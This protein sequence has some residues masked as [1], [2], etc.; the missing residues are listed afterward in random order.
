MTNEE[1][2]LHLTTKI[3]ALESAN[4]QLSADY[5]R[6][7]ADYT[8]L[9]ANYENIIADN[10]KLA[11]LIG[12]KDA[13]IANL[14][15]KIKDLEEKINQNP[16]NS[17]KPPSSEP[18]WKERKKK[19]PSGKKKG[20]QPGHEG[21]SR[22]LL[23]IEQVDERHSI[24]PETCN[25][26]GHS[27]R[28]NARKVGEPDIRQRIELPTKLYH[29]TQFE[30][31]TLECPCCGKATRAE[32]PSDEL[33]MMFGPRMSAFICM[34]T[35]WFRISRREAC[36]MLEEVF[37]IH[38][39]VGTI[40]KLEKRMAKATKEEYEAIRQAVLRE[41]V[42]GIDETGWSD[43]Q[44][45]WT[46]QSSMYSLFSI[47]PGR[48]TNDL[49]SIIG[50]YDGYVMSDRYG[51]YNAIELDK[52]QSCQAH[53]SR[54]YKAVKERGGEHEE[55]AD[56]LIALKDKVFF[57]W[58]RFKSGEISRE[59]L[60]MQ[61]KLPIEMFEALLE[62]GK[63]MNLPKTSG[64]CKNLLKLFPSLWRFIFVE[65]VDPT[66]NGSE[67]DIRKPVLW[68]KSSFGSRSE[69][70]ARYAEQLP[71]ICGTAKKQGLAKLFHIA[72][73]FAKFYNLPLLASNPAL[74]P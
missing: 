11:D 50:D 27:F 7:S 36:N 18:P 21:H 3:K 55:L 23:P 58:H 9:S 5:T 65:G 71:S 49:L 38:V 14:E 29:L 68:R 47:R 46:L 13:F 52:R 56:K 26:C 64:L 16:S 73:L 2:I 6:L 24:D 25:S 59:E 43:K 37:G 69:T 12:N 57:E 40:S 54:D 35:S 10:R 53:L 41:K 17:S 34:M 22:K 72:N 70:G 30:Y 1:I 8:R 42:V 28:G 39:S 62:R 48:S 19:K 63:K 67:R 32:I 15:Q 20:G 61:S 45:F 33:Q 60:Q 74:A 51:V 44:W 4:G 66:N 31:N